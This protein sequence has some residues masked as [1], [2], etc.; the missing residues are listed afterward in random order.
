ATADFTFDG[1]VIK[2][3]TTIHLLCEPSGTD[4]RGCEQPAFDIAAEGRPPHLAFGG[5]VHYCLGHL[6]APACMSERR[7]VLAR[8]LRDPAAEGVAV[9]LRCSGNTGPVMLPMAFEPLQQFFAAT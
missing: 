2:A 6:I 8:G 9:W 5:G 3:G 4:P 1:L 7:A